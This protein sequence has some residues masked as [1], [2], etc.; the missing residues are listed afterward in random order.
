MAGQLNTQGAKGVKPTAFGPSSGKPQHPRDPLRLIPL[1]RPY[2]LSPVAEYPRVQLG[3]GRL[4]AALAC[5]VLLVIQGCQRSPAAAPPPAE[6][7]QAPVPTEPAAPAPEGGQETPR[8][9]TLRLS[10]WHLTEPH[11]EKAIKEM[12]QVLEAENPDLRVVLVPVAYA[13]K[14]TLYT[15]EIQAG[16]G[17]DLL[18]LHG[19]S[20]HSFIEKGFLLDITEFLRQSP[21][22]SWGGSFVDT[23]YP[24]TMELMKYRGSY[25]ALPSD[26]M[27]MVLFYN[28]KLYTE[29]GL[30]P[31]AAPRTWDEFLQN[32]KALTRDRNGDGAIDT[33]GFG[34]V[35]AVDPGFE[36]RFTPFLLSFG[37]NYLTAD[38]KQCA[39]NSPEAK[40]AF[41]FYV[42][43]VTE[44]KVV[45]PEVVTQNPGNVRQQMASQRIAMKIGSGWTV[46]IQSSLNPSLDAASVLAATPIPQKAGRSI[47]RP[48]TAWISAWMINKNTQHPQEAWRLLKFMT[49]KRADEKWFTD[50][51]V[52]SAR[53]DVSGGLEARGVMPFGPLMADPLSWVIAAELARSQFVPQIKEWPQI[54]EIVNRAVQSGFSG[55]KTPEQALADTFNQINRILSVY[56]APGESVAEF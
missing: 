41:R 9:V 26:F 25:F 52:L 13:D 51:R 54:I 29:A 11:W 32:A 4:F 39:L 20:I 42:S 47:D 15:T 49:S 56:R 22:T 53:R 16:A 31:D 37:A 40:E 36:L 5:L 19:F 8:A 33:W 12:M 21:R 2:I 17:P 3:F 44:T 18:H 10:D 7:P 45:P 6:N 48:T 28:R 24:V 43:L 30:D 38:G 14:E 46:P 55:A 1:H 35:G 50:A 27:S 23:W 34:T